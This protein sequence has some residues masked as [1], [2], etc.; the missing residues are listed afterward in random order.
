MK[1]PSNEQLR[2]IGLVAVLWNEIIFSTDC[3]LYSGLGLPQGTWVDIVGQIPE[4][5]KGEFLQKAADDLR[6]PSD[7]RS[8]IAVTASAMSCLKKHRDAVVHSTPFNV[9]A[10]LGHVIGRGQAF[11]IL[12]SPQTLEVLVRHLQ[13]LREEAQTITMLF[14]ELRALLAATSPGAQFAEG[15]MLDEAQL[16]QIL[17]RLRSQQSA[18]QALPA[19]VSLPR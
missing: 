11:E 19:L 2:S 12:G 13:G 7:L 5:V 10:G 3:A 15:R 16:A 6:L 14:D 17:A 1:N 18:R 4:A 9:T 8:A